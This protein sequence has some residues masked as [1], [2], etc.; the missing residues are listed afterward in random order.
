MSCC[1]EFL[2]LCHADCYIERTEISKTTDKANCILK[3][4]LST[5]YDIGT[6]R[7]HRR[8]SSLI[9]CCVVTEAEFASFS[10]ICLYILLAFLIIKY[11]KFSKSC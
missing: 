4:T 8:N 10:L 2:T 3:P 11:F 7:G 9:M 6:T 1:P 5:N